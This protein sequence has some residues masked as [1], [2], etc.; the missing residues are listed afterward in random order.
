MPPPSKTE[1]YT[2]DDL[3]LPYVTNDSPIGE[4]PQFSLGVN[5][6]TSIT[7]L[8]ER[9][10]GFATALEPTPVEYGNIKRLFV[11][12]R[13]DDPVSGVTRAAF[14]CMMN[15]CAG[16]I[17]TVY[18]L[19]IGT[20]ASFVQIHQ[21]ATTGNPFDFVASN[22]QCYFGNGVAGHM[23]R[24]DGTTVNNWGIVKPSALSLSLGGTSG[25]NLFPTAFTNPD[26]SVTGA[27]GFQN[28]GN[29][30]DPSAVTAAT[31]NGHSIQYLIGPPPFTTGTA[32][33]SQSCLWRG[34][35]ATPMTGQ[36]L[37][38]DYA[39]LFSG[40]AG[41]PVTANIEYS[42]DAGATW[43]PAVSSVSASVSRA[44]F[45]VVLSDVQDFSLVQVRSSASGG[46]ATVTASST[47]FVSLYSIFIGDTTATG[48]PG[49]TLSSVDGFSYVA[50]Y[51][52]G[53]GTGST[54]ISI[55][56]SSPSDLSLSTGAFDGSGVTLSLVAS[57]D[58]QV[59]QIH[60][61]RN[62]E[63]GSLAPEEMQE[64]AGS[65]FANSTI[66]VLDATADDDLSFNTA[67]PV[68][69]ND[70]PP[71]AMGWVAYAS[72]LWGFLSNTLY[73]SGYEEIGRG[74]PEECFP[75][76]IDGNN[77]SYAKDIHSLGV[78]PDGVAVSTSTVINKVEGD[79]LDT[80][81]FYGI[82]E[83]RG[84]R[85]IPNMSSIGGTISWLDTSGTVWNSEFGEIS[86]PVRPDTQSIDQSLSAVTTHVSGNFHW[87]VVM[88]GFTG[89]LLI[90]DIDK[91]QW[92]PPWKVGP[93]IGCIGSFETSEGT[94][95]LLIA[96]RGKKVMQLVPGVYTDD[97]SS[98][99]SFVVTN[100]FPIAPKQSR[101]WKGVID[102]IEWKRNNIAIS[103]IK[104]LT[105]DDPTLGM[106][107]AL[108]EIQPS[109]DITQGTYL[110]T[111]RAVSNFPT[112]QL[113]SLRFDWAEATTN[114]KLY[115]ISL[116]CHPVGQ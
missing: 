116:A 108:T 10:P 51:G 102:W 12:Q 50:T 89:K 61:Y 93:S 40:V 66:L 8:L 15:D 46:T 38:I 11:W 111:E 107:K 49:T 24:Y 52:Y 57:S 115:E 91:K 101:Q 9:R 98:Y 113:A 20:D 105:D 72:R 87:I 78:L 26:P 106:F 1:V 75:S 73:Y 33:D 25:A 95:N 59:N 90:F 34:F 2:I 3:A 84:T 29:A 92:L 114:F 88:D 37:S 62:P 67:P 43:L 104:Q 6:L 23:K 74:V 65:P 19:Q 81:R 28:P 100:Q 79:S 63:G 35:A 80:F 44:I 54:A 60:V 41:N 110:L 112:A 47:M 53:T 18:K 39:F 85:S 83:K 27:T 42:L 45:N 7:G 30:Y 14:I 16:G 48:T 99:N 109:P 56:E 86:I 77:H 96:L 64:I 94:T 55:G 103:S 68:N 22:N 17:S 71:P 31:G 5:V 69:R 36:S 70:P 4:D 58:P 21:D 97:G 76:G 32:S 82:L 13:W